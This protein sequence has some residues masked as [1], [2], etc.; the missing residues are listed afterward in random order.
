MQH[1]EHIQFLNPTTMPSIPGYSQIAKVHGGQ[2][3]YISGQVALDLEGN[4]VGPGDFRA[5]AQQVFE[6]LKAALT[7]AGADFSHVVKLG[8]YLTDINQLP[9]LREVRN[10]Y[11]NTQTPP[12]STAVEV[13]RLF[14]EGILVEVDAIAS[15][16]EE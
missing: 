14:R 8:L 1:P 4:L 7:E 15:L 10:Q 2:T 5:Q 3:I 9:I 13:S 16:P 6:N 11:V 12:A